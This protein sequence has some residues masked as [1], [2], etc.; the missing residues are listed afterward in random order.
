MDR[1]LELVE[2]ALQ[3]VPGGRRESE[4]SFLRNLMGDI[5]AGLQAA[6]QSPARLFRTMMSGGGASEDLAA[7]LEI[8][9][10]PSERPRDALRAG[11]W[12]LRVVPGTG[13]VG[14]LTVLVSGDLQ[15]SEALAADGIP[16][17]SAQ[18]GQYGLVIEAGAFRHNRSRPFAR[19][20]LDSRGRV[21]PHSMILRPRFSQDDPYLDHPA[22]SP[23]QPTP[24]A[25]SASR[26]QEQ[27]IPPPTKTRVRDQFAVPFRW[28]TRVSLRKN[29]IEES[30]GS[31]VLISD[32]HVLTAAHVVWKAKMSPGEY[33]VEVT[34]AHDGVN[35]LDRFGVSRI[36][37]PKLYKAGS[38]VFDYSILTLNAP[39][40]NRTYK[41]LGG[42]RL[43][44]WG[45][46][47]CGA[48]T[49]AE[50]V[51][52]ASLNGQ[53]AITA[54][55]PRDKGGNQMWVVTGTMSRS[56]GGAAA[57][58]YT[59]ELIEGQSGSPAWVEQNGVRNIVGLVASRGSFNRLYPLSWEMVTELNGWMLRAE[60]TSARP[61]ESEAETGVEGDRH[62][63]EDTEMFTPPAW[64]KVGRRSRR[65]TPSRPQSAEDEAVEYDLDSEDGWVA[66]DAFVTPPWLKV[67][68]RSRRAQEDN[69]FAPDDEGFTFDPTGAQKDFGPQLRKAWHEM[70]KAAFKL[71]ID[72]GIDQIKSKL[73][74]TTA[75][76]AKH[77][78]FFSQASR[79]PKVTLS[80]ANV[81]WR[82][83]PTS[84]GAPSRTTYRLFDDPAASGS[85]LRTQDEYCEWKVFRDSAGKIVRVV[86]TSEPPEY[87]QFLYDPGV[88]SLTKFAQAL[89]V[90]LYQDRC[91]NTAIKLADLETTV[92]G[93]KQYDP[94]NKWNNDHC[95]HL[96]QPNN[97][98]GAQI[99]IAARAA[100]LRRD[101]SGSIITSVKTLIGCDPF[102]E[103]SRQS[104][105]NIGDNVNKL[106]RENRFLTLQNPVGLYMVSLDTSGWVTPDGTD[107]Q[108][109]W[110][111]VKGKVDKDPRKSMIVRADYAV[112]A[113]KKYTVSDITIGG[114]PIEFG[115]Q[116]AEQ[117][118][119]RL[120]AMFGPRDKDP[121]GRTTTAPTPV[122][123]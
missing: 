24:Y 36:D 95:V 116:I 100:I 7:V 117:L 21:P 101:S 112:P 54:G 29:G 73:G 12:M 4:T 69:E 19:R 45:S 25:E 8:V 63:A 86:F 75:E 39:V 41:A 49:T 11:D 27:V 113:S 81:P 20:W 62:F 78:R 71:N 48:G 92:S 120:G 67:G 91:G 52:P 103:P 57:I 9:A 68:R 74:L 23:D 94:G 118:E 59:G 105:P 32:V 64:L 2:R 85:R 80:A 30:H 58:H 84:G 5:D 22:T 13:D 76:A 28:M 115:S 108:T 93:V 50:P 61:A 14:H 17:E 97:T 42:A 60:K 104:D 53:V 16:A 106:A 82:A 6:I 109:F 56:V 122:P 1:N 34:L 44:Y 35:F 33:S 47:A 88:A 96:Q 31:G 123:C 51:N 3:L 70:L 55:Y 10:R 111:V 90:K 18:D 43:C 107:A 15:T 119:M 99:N 40:A 83:F 38:D 77:M 89:L 87:Y 26:L 121:E 102:G 72:D 46:S 66:D 79:T 37:V 110:K 114:A 98:L 65:A